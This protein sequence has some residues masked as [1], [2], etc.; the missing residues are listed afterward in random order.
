M[1]ATHS[2]GLLSRIAPSLCLALPMFAGCGASIAP[3]SDPSQAREIVKTTLDAWKQG[4]TPQA[5]ATKSPSVRV[6]DR[7]W[8]DGSTLI[9]YELKGEG[10][11]LGQDIQQSV[12]LNLKTP[13]GKAVK[14]TVNYVVTTGS[15][16]MV[17]RQD[18]D[19]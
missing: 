17:A 6:K 16:P 8:G 3:P 1:N 11:R 9:D 5:L 18:I 13:K 12:A 2:R 19:E 7:E 15:Y 10:Q 14:K 4:E